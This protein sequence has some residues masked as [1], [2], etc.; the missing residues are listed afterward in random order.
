MNVGHAITEALREQRLRDV[1][2][3]IREPRHRDRLLA[4]WWW[5]W[6]RGTTVTTP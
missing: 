6:C 5:G 1:E 3:M 2:R 4:Y